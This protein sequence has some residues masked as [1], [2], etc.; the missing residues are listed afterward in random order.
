MPIPVPPTSPPAPPFP[1]LTCH[2]L[3][4]KLKAYLEKSTMTV[5]FP[6]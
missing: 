3:L 4:K 1:H 6:H 2:P 5:L